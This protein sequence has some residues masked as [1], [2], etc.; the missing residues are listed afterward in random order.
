MATAQQLDAIINRPRGTRL[1]SLPLDIAA[2]T[3]QRIAEAARRL[4]VPERAFA[5]WLLTEAIS[6]FEKREQRDQRLVKPNKPTSI[7]APIGVELR[8]YD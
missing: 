1:R 7:P 5:E 4:G 2:M 8:V 6:A 3:E